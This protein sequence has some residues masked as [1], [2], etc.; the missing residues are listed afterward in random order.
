MDTIES[1]I[2]RLDERVSTRSLEGLE[3]RIWAG[4]AARTKANEVS[5]LVVS[6]Q[7]GLMIVAIIGSTAA[8]AVTGTSAA[9]PPPEVAIFSDRTDL[10]PSTL[11]LGS[12][13]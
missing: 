5:R 13:P 12:Y 3:G 6:C 2:H 8:G 1:A 10:T 7:V 4:V 11:L 9:N